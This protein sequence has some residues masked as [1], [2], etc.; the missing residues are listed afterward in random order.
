M[1]LLY[2]KLNRDWTQRKSNKIMLYPFI[3]HYCTHNKGI[4]SHWNGR[5]TEWD[6]WKCMR[7]E[8]GIHEDMQDIFW[9]I[10]DLKI[11]MLSG[12]SSHNSV[13]HFESSGEEAKLNFLPTNGIRSEG[14]WFKPSTCIDILFYVTRRSCILYT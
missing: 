9:F 1:K 5:F 12:Q 3:F 8:E 2:I 13:P 6:F 7:K 11:V 14:R 10:L 4:K